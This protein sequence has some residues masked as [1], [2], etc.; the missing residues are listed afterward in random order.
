MKEINIRNIAITFA[1]ALIIWFIPAPEGV[2]GNAWHLFAIFAATILGIILKA[3][4]MGTMCMMAI[5]FTA[6]TQVVAPGDAGKSITKALSGFGDK[7]IWLIGIS[8][9][10]ARG[11]IKT[12]LG[13]RIAFLFIRIFGKSSLGL[14]Y[15]LGLADVCLAPAI[16]SNTARGG[17]IIYPIMKSMAISFDSVPEKPETHRKLG[18]F[19]TLNSY[20][21][22]LIAS[23]MFLTGTA[24]NPMCQKFAANLGINITWMS[25]AAAGFVPGLVAFFVVPLVLYKLYPPELKKTGDAPKMAAQKLKEMGPISRNEWLMLLAFFILLALWIFGGAL[26]I[27]ATTTAFIGLTM[28]LLTSVLTW[29]DIKGEKGAWDTIVWFAVLV[30]MA[31]SLNELGFIGWFSDLIKVKIGG[32]SWQVAFPVIIVVYFFSHYIFASAT[33]HVAAMYAALLGVGVSLGIPPMLLAM[34]L[35]FL[36]SIYGVLTHYGHGP[37]PVF[38]GS[39]YVE[40][41]AWWLRGLEIGIVLLIIYMVVGGLW[42]KVLGYY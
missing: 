14:A 32:L 6:L 9:F 22:N 3:A 41:K 33:A 15:G 4:P 11:F 34:M 25:W 16:P 2:A 39:G 20:Y 21:M 35:G 1:V 23:S 38:Y 24:S 18:S 31:S 10:I 19:L 13:N 8:F 29:E 36:G 27:D 17:G 7:V 5:A 30:M 37:A 40:L 26:S 12:G 28:L 42:M